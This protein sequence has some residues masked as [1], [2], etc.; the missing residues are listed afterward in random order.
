VKDDLLQPDVSIATAADYADALLVARRAK[1]ILTLI[2]FVLLILQ[3]GV[4][5]VA[6]WTDV[7]QTTSQP[8]T[9]P[10][11]T[12]DMLAYA[13]A[14]SLYLGMG[15][16]VMLPLVL[17][18]T[19]H[20]MLVGRLIGVGA[21]VSALAWS[22]LLAVVLFPWQSIL[23]TAELSKTDFVIP[24]VLYTW[25]E[26]A[27]RVPLTSSD[28]LATILYWGRFVG[29]PVI[30]LIILLMVHVRSGRGLRVSLGEAPVVDSSR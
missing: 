6:H 28:L 24:G 25:R 2:L 23:I 29:A 7:L 4:F 1:R 17:W 9:T 18:I 21:V 13:S 3:L 16:A 5:G 10:V 22:L 26:V 14:V 15:C 12:A 19:S 20:I 8:S 30:A 11:A 27:E